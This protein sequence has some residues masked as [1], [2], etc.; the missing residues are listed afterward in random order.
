MTQFK[1]FIDSLLQEPS[2][3]DYEN[4]NDSEPTY[5]IPA[6]I[7]P[8]CE[9]AKEVPELANIDW[10][11]VIASLQKM[12]PYASARYLHGWLKDVITDEKTLNFFMST[13]PAPTHL[14]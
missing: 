6:D 2:F 7:L 8:R 5:Y 11:K 12:P 14:V 9:Q 4:P 1:D 10:D 13:L 3:Y